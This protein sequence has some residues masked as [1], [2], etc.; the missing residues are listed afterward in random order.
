[1][2]GAFLA[3]MVLSDAAKFAINQ[4]NEHLECLLITRSPLEQKLADGL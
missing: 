3:E 4:R 2:I 1:V